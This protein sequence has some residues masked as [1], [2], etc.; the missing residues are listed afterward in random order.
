MDIS[1]N[2]YVRNE[3]YEPGR[4]PEIKEGN[5]FNAETFTEFNQKL[6]ADKK[7]ALDLINDTTENVTLDYKPQSIMQFDSFK[8]KLHEE[9]MKNYKEDNK[10]PN[11]MGRSD[12]KFASS[13]EDF[14]RIM[15]EYFSKNPQD[16]YLR[17]FLTKIGAKESNFRNVQNDAGAPAYGY[18]Q[19]W[20]TNLDGLT[21]EQLLANPQK[22]VELAVKL[23]KYNLSQLK[24]RDMEAL[25]RMGVSK[26]G[27]LGGMWL[28]G[29]GGLTKWL[30]EG[31]DRSDG[32]HYPDGKGATVGSYVKTFNSYKQG[33]VI[34]NNDIKVGDKKYSVKIA[35]TD[36]DKEVGL[37]NKE[38]LSDNTGML[39]IIDPKDKDRDGVIWFTM[40]D[41]KIP[42]DIIFID[43]DFKVNQISQGVPYSKDPIFGKADFVLEVN[44]ESGINI[45]DEL[46]FVDDKELNDKMFVL[47]SEGRPQM[48]L[49][50]GE[51]IMSIQ[52]TKTLIKFAKKANVTGDKNDFKAL[53][54]RV[55]K[56]I[57]TQNNNEPE[58]VEKRDN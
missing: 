56:F 28:G 45:G 3:A 22:Q 49:E 29:Y 16:S 2:I 23:A 12:Y 55:F 30:H 9:L 47:D 39:F 32:H 13:P 10:L 58:Y 33:G 40:E 18:F 46:E 4:E 1:K 48:I 57:E 19:L 15:D 5:Q 6:E 20:K 31:V 42:L 17:D 50:G 26:W 53:G 34:T 27:A 8:K 24:D 43:D 52:N 38:S 21:P 37:S 41:T 51:R 54:K 36:E 25:T 11:I 44:P 14:E 7:A 35:Q